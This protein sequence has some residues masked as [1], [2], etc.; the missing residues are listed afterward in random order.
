MQNIRT[1]L[2]LAIENVLLVWGSV[3]LALTYTST[4]HPFLSPISWY[5]IGSAMIVLNFTRKRAPRTT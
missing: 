3:I 5:L 4:S 2:V 1:L